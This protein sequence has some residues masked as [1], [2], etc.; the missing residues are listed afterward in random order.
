MIDNS[1]IDSPLPTCLFFKER[2][3]PCSGSCVRLVPQVKVFEDAV[4][5]WLVP[6]VHTSFRSCAHALEK[7]L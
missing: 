2:K 3:R 1:R 7:R 5:T 6:L 4:C